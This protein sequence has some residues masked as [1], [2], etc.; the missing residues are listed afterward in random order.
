MT[1]TAELSVLIVEDDDFQRAMIARMLRLQGVASVSDADN[2]R[3]AIDMIRMKTFQP[4]IVFCDLNM[5]E[6]DGL[7]F[8]RH[9]GREQQNT[10]IVII[11]A[12]GG[13]LL[14]SAGKMAQM[15][16]IKMLGVVEKPVLPDQVRLLLSRYDRSADKQPQQ[17]VAPARFT[18]N[19]IL[20]GVRAGQFEPWR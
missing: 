5:P 10:A 12:L 6:M 2:G 19:E 7:E 16:G 15:Y 11:S 8:L 18:L 14:V 13:K 17:P 3:T 20:Q 1:N 4:D 9:L